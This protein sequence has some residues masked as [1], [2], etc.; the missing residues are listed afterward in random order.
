[1]IVVTD[2]SPLHYLVLVGEQHLLEQHYG[3]VV[4]PHAVLDECA[5]LHAPEKLRLWAAK[6]PA[7]RH[8]VRDSP[9]QL[10]GL[11]QLDPGE[12]A[13]IETARTLGAS[14]LLMDEKKGRL[15]AEAHG[16]AV[17]GVLG[18]L[19][20]AAKRGLVDFEEVMARL[21]QQTNFLISE[22]LIQY[23]RTTLRNPVT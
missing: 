6:P 13:A 7:W 14:I 1:M 16:F 4:C 3:N 18:I 23:A 15:A 2:A 11:D 20:T 12:K 5:H 19:V 8:V 10:S 9:S 21:T 22:A 17:V